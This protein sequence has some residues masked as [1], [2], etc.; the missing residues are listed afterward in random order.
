MVPVFSTCYRLDEIAN[1]A[2]PLPGTSLFF[3][4]SSP[5]WIQVAVAVSRL[6]HSNKR[7]A[8]G[9]HGTQAP[10][11]AP[12]CLSSASH[13]AAAHCPRVT[14]LEPETGKVLF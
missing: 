8:Q 5:M 9:G 12:A 4:F 10:G 14:A 1:R 6:W 3:L 11:G 13:P 2:R 7:L